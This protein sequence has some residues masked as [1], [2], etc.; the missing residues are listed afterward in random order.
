M[1]S[2][3]LVNPRSRKARRA[4]KRRRKAIRRRARHAAPRRRRRAIR[5]GRAIRRY[6]RNPIGGLPTVNGVLGTVKTAAVGAGGAVALDVVFGMLPLP[7]SLKIGPMSLA[8]KG[9]GAVALGYG[10]GKVTGNRSLG[11]QVT[12]GSLTILLYRVIKD[13]VAKFAPGLVMG[14][15]VN[16]MSEYV[17]GLGYLS[18]APTMG[19]LPDGFGGIN[20]Q[21]SFLTPAAVTGFGGMDDGDDD[22]FGLNG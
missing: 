18:P 8:A 10:V 13:Q 1:P 2:I 22:P 16:G 20:A 6:K 9:L 4:P 3:T 7:D 12:E 11:A 15:Y 5:R 14:E 19:Q 21:G 17:N